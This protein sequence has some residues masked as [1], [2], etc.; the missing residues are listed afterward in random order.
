M[1]RVNTI[2]WGLLLIL[3]AFI[4]HES[5]D[6][7]YYGSDFGPGPGFFSFWLGIL[8]MVM[9]FAQIVMI[10]RRPADP[11][12][13]GF[14]PDREGIKRML[15]VMGALAASLLLMNILGFSLTILLFCI[16]LLRTLGRRQSWW[17]TLTLS[18]I[19]SFGTSYLFGLLQVALPK[20]F[21][22]VI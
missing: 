7:N 1:K 4:V 21:L 20:G 6:H 10:Y 3:G 12:P 17:L 14:I 2:I 11:L 16:F 13:A 22:G 8:L 5:L 19:G 15:Y 9:S 18:V